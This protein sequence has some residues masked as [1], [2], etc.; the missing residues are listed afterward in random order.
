MSICVKYDPKD[1]FARI[2][3][4]PPHMVTAPYGKYVQQI[5]DELF[6]GPLKECKKLLIGFLGTSE[7]IEISTRFGS[8]NTPQWVNT[9]VVMEYAV[10][11]EKYDA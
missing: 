1:V 6:N 10:F 11:N 4:K 2:P 9:L 5:F 3:I 8:A 7:V